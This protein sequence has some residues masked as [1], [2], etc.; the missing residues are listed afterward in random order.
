MWNKY[1]HLMEIMEVMKLIEYDETTFLPRLLPSLLLS[2]APSVVAFL[3]SFLSALGCPYLCS[4]VL[5]VEEDF[6]FDFAV[7]EWF[8][9][10]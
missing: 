4:V 1:E 2:F 10:Y 5:A 8:R 7:V 3:P 9:S 6:P